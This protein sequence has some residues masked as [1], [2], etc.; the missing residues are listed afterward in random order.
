ML[1]H[2]TRTALYAKPDNKPRK[3]FRVSVRT[4]TRT[5]DSLWL[6][7]LMASVYKGNPS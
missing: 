1:S 3:M 6:N 7:S 4:A 5:I 2:A